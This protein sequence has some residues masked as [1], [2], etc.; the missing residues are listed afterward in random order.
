MKPS[1]NCV[2]SAFLGSKKIGEGNL[3][4]VASKVRKS[5]DKGKNEPVF[6]FDNQTSAQLEVDFRGTPEAVINRLEKSFTQEL[7]KSAGPGR[8]KLGVVSREISLLPRHWEWLAVQ[9]GGASATLRKLVEEAKKKNFAQD[10]IREAQE[11]AYKFMT[12]MAGDLANYEEALRALY[13]K[14]MEL[15][16]KLISPWPKDVREHTL[17]LARNAF[18]QATPLKK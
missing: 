5:L 12:V 3:L 17:K 13:A 15:F 7:E 10:R 2:C 14:N 9:P 8:P 11:A 1:T 6:I 18:L 4:E 16:E